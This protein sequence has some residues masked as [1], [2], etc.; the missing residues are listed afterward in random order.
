MA[1]QVPLQT[2][3]SVQLERGSEV[4][5]GATGIEPVKDV[6]GPDIE[7]NR[8][9][10]SELSL[11]IM[12]LDNELSDAEGKQLANDYATELNALNNEYSNLKGV[13]AVGTVTVGDK[14]IPVFE[15]YQAKAKALHDSYD[16]KASSGTVKSIFRSKAS[17]YTRG[18]LDDATKHSLK[19][20][21]D[22]NETETNKEIELSRNNAKVH[23]ETWND[24]NGKFRLNYSIGLAKI[25]EKA[26]LKGWNLDPEAVDAHGNKIG[27]SSQY[28]DAVEKYN[29]EIFKAVYKS[30][31]EKKDFTGAEN[32][33]RSLD[34]SGKSK[35]INEA[36]KKVTAR[37][38]EHN[39]IGDGKCVDSIISNN[40]DQNDGRYSSQSDALLCL[41]SNQAHDNGKG[42]SVIDGENSDEVD[43]TDRTQSEN[44]EGLDQRRSTSKFYSS[45]SSLK[46]TLIPQHQTTHLFA[47]QKLGVKQADSL[48]TKAESSIE[49]DKERFKVDPEYAT[50]INKQIITNYN[51]LILE[52]A[53]AKYGNKDRLKLETQIAELEKAPNYY[54]PGLS[55][56]SPSQ[57]DII[58]MNKD[59]VKN[60]KLIELR[61]KLDKLEENDPKYVEKIANDLNII[62]NGIDYNYGSEESTIK[63][64]PVTGLQPLEVLKA[65]L[66]A[67][68]T[69]PKELATATKDLEIKYNKI[70]TE[71]EGLYKGALEKAQEIA[72]AEPGGWKQL[73]ANNIDINDFTEAD[74]EI[75]RNGP[76][77]ESDTATLV[78]LEEK[79]PNELI[80]NLNAY[81]PKLSATQFLKL[82]Q[83][84]ES[85][86]AD[87]GSV[88]AVTIDNDMLDLTLNKF[89]FGFIKDGKFDDNDYLEIKGRWKQLIDE[90]QTRT[91]G[92]ISRE[93]K[94]ELLNQI[95]TNTVIYDYGVLRGDHRW[96]SAIINKNQMENTY[97]KVGGETIWLKTIPAFQREKIIKKIRAKG[98][99]V[100]EQLIAD[101][102]VFGGKSKID[103]QF[104]WDKY[105]LEKG[106]S[107]TSSL[108]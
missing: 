35:D 32:F 47:I 20:Q 38:K 96:P 83:Y 76:P 39:L 27:I 63:I 72:F 60:K 29:M 93:R 85:L 34:P 89:D 4:Q 100:T 77:E 55:T 86:K 8:K 84:S 48:Y 71:R 99:P 78:K 105:N 25:Q 70:K 28:Y 53:E 21:R 56:G 82:K 13:N 57:S 75:L 14:Q 49:I 104:E 58:N 2:A 16:E 15:H 67:T 106:N 17:V 68:I 102:W 46:G 7:R 66:K 87:P 6:V 59:L 40:G 79:D 51:K 98:L 11:S 95:L 92:K 1:L 26:E 12:K 24:P 18:F 23:F 5:Y 101:M 103:N 107:S 33:L 94:Q 44:L 91:K 31:E 3:P 36:L 74:Q 80:N 65:K 43:T 97:V 81:R 19:Q 61:G 54:N 41:R 10:Q 52:A 22:Y 9:A 69:D 73:Q 62:T 30:L 88:L 90:E 64:D 37:H 42:G 108:K 45:E 50:E